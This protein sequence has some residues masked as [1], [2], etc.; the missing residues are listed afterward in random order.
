VDGDLLA[1]LYDPQTS[2]GLLAAVAPA[3]ADAA[4]AA[5]RAPGATVTRI[6]AV[7][8]ASDTRVLVT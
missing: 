5:I 1:L 7:L 4:E 2:G 8:P 3:A 6:G